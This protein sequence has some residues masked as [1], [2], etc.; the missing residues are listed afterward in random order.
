ML[1]KEAGQQKKASP[2]DGN[3]YRSEQTTENVVL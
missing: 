1:D 2:G 3:M